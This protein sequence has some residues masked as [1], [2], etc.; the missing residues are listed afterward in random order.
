MRSPVISV[1]CI[2]TLT[3]GIWLVVWQ[4]AWADPDKSTTPGHRVLK[5]NGEAITAMAFSA[6][7]SK[8]ASATTEGTLSLWTLATGKLSWSCKGHKG[9]IHALAFTR[10]GKKLVSAGADRVI[11]SRDSATGKKVDE[12][13]GHEGAVSALAFSPDEKLLA[14]ASYDKTIR[15]WDFQSKKELRKLLGHEGRVSSIAFAS[16]GETLVSGGTLAETYRL[17]NGNTVNAGQ[18]DRVRIWSIGKQGG[19]KQLESRGSAV[20]ISCDQSFLAAGG[21][22]CKVDQNGVSGIDTISLVDLVAERVKLTLE[23]RGCGIAFSP[24]GRLLASSLGSFDYLLGLGIVYGWGGKTDHRLSLWEALTGNRI[25]TISD[26]EFHVISFGPRGTMLAAGYVWGE[27][28]LFDI[29]VTL[30]SK[31]DPWADKKSFDTVWDHLGQPD[32]AAAY[33]EMYALMADEVKCVQFIREKVTPVPPEREETVR[34]ILGA[35]DSAVVQER[36]KAVERLRVFAWSFEPALRKELQGEISLEKSKRLK[37]VLRSERSKVP[38]ADALRNSRIISILEALDS[39]G[40]RS[41][42]EVLSTGA[43]SSRLT[44]EAQAALRRLATSERE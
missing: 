39:K 41:A 16:D 30:R 10:D 12:L 42:L 29:P 18:T 15:L 28:E 14:S 3:L 33:P 9:W 26:K 5:G 7:G 21:L 34:K 11:A 25:A 32:P 6:D 23:G 8:L 20:A 19:V 1:A 40:S 27:I 31:I 4:S 37:E 36:D 44:R 35:L 2:S 13:L 43:P 22:V 38:D 17:G 24:D